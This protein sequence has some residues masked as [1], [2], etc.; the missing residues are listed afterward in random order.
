MTQKNATNAENSSERHSDY[1]TEFQRKCFK[2]L[3]ETCKTKNISILKKKLL[4]AVCTI[5]AV[6]SGIL[7]LLGVISR[8]FSSTATKRLFLLAL[9]IFEAVSCYTK[10]LSDIENKK[11]SI[12]QKM[13]KLLEDIIQCSEYKQSN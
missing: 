1:I 9:G 12:S 4:L 3:S 7:I 11:I 8:N 10:I 2:K 5:S 6:L 13:V